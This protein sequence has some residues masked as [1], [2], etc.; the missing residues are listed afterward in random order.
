MTRRCAV[1]ILPRRRSGAPVPRMRARVYVCACV[2]G[3]ATRSRPFPCRASV[4]SG[5]QPRSPTRAA[6]TAAILVL[7]RVEMNSVS[8]HC[9]VL[10]GD[11]SQVENALREL[12]GPA[13]SPL[14]GEGTQGKPCIHER[15]EPPS[16]PR[17]PGAGHA[18]RG[19]HRCPGCAD[20]QQLRRRS[21]W[22]HRACL[23]PETGDPRAG[24]VMLPAVC[25]P[26][27]PITAAARRPCGG[28]S[29]STP[30]G[31]QRGPCTVRCRCSSCSQLGAPPRSVCAG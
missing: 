5:R 24:R 9:E 12:W 30:R 31:P 28:V 2:R 29:S 21:T 27:A 7:C 6:V 15:W 8:C 20:Q 23:C 22:G 4:L 11:G 17:T 26:P 18:R 25:A 10:L 19:R 3:S 13:A 16:T 1:S 14:A